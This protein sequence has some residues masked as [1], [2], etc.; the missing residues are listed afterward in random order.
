KPREDLMTMLSLGRYTDMTG[1]TW[2]LSPSIGYRPHRLVWVVPSIAHGFGEGDAET[3]IGLGLWLSFESQARIRCP[4]ISTMMAPK[5]ETTMI[6]ISAAAS[7]A[8]TPRSANRNDA[9]SAPTTPI[10]T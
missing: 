3:S 5:I 7:S 2:K 1:T 9:A 10:T 6:S 4:I 8:V